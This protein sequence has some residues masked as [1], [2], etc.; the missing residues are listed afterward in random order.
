MEETVVTREVLLEMFEKG[1]LRDTGKG[2]L[3]EDSKWI[4][5]IALHDVDP[6]YIEDVTRA[7]FYK[8]IVKGNK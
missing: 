8:I 1:E 2:W 3:F 6:K 7:E 5:I 4:E